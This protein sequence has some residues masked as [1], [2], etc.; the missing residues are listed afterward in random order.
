MPL[1]RLVRAGRRLSRFLDCGFD[2]CDL[3]C[4]LQARLDAVESYDAEGHANARRA[5]AA[6]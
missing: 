2:R 3:R 6:V 1:L 5:T 4:Q